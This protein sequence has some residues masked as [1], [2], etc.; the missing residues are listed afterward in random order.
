MFMKMR[1]S[2]VTNS[3]SSSF[4]IDKKDISKEKLKEILLRLANIDAA[5]WND[6]PY[7]EDDF[8]GDGIGR[9]NILDSDSGDKDE[10][11]YW[12][13]GYINAGKWIVHNDV[14]I[15]YNWDDVEDAFE[16][17]GVNIAYG[18]CC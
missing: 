2:F 10:I 9:Y 13:N 16:E 17:E 12:T 18:H 4:I 6:E 8:Y 3:S 14:T 5:D 1:L 7:T 15:H 11:S